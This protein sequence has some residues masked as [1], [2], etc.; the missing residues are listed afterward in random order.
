MKFSPLIGAAITV[1]LFH[2]C[3]TVVNKKQLEEQEQSQ[4]MNLNGP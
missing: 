2:R 1:E 3:V 4:K